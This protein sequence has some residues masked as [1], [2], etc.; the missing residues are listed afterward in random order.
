M[1]DCQQAIRLNPDFA[2]SYKRLYKAQLALGNI[3]EAQEALKIA[4]EKDPT[5]K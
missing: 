3:P 1:E 5:D 4:V 2:R